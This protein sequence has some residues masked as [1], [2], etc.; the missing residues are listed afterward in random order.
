ME[1]TKRNETAKCVAMTVLTAAAVALFM[2]VLVYPAGF[3]PSGVDGLATILQ[4][5]TGWNAGIFTLAIN[6]PLLVAAYFVLK[7][8]YV[9]YT[10][11]YTVL[12]S[13][14]L[15]LLER[16][17]FY[18]YHAPNDRLLAALFGGV[19][20]G[21][22]GVM[23]RIGASSGG[24]DTVAS[25]IQKRIP[26]KN[27]ESIVA[28]LC[29][30]IL[31]LSFFV[32]RSLNSLLLA[33]VE[34]FVCERVTSAIL[35]SSRNAV[36]FEIVTENAEPIKTHILR[37]LRHG[38]TVLSASGGYSDRGKHMIVCVV[39]YREIPVFLR[40]L[41]DYPDTFVYYSDVMGIRGNFDRED[42]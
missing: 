27:V 35:R 10:V 8:R 16:I 22:T 1:R 17:D 42:L 3:A 34:I 15:F 29:C 23:F 32:Y 2:H 37:R 30:A 19:G 41:S 31:L 9:A 4:Y 26:H 11:L 12:F 14:F 6:L 38:V 36:K 7:R 13:A 18:Q 20:Q 39:N 40:L 28:L 21:L 25:M 33:A 5:V 24:V